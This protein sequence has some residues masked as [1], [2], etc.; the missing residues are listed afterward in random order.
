MYV[1]DMIY[2]RKSYVPNSDP[3]WTPNVMFDIEE[4]EFLTDILFPIT[5]VRIK[6]AVNDTTDAIMLE[7]THL[8]VM[9]NCAE[10]FW[11]I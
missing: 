3:W 7:L 4:L 2:K 1:I 11:E 9:I 8:Y 6:P 10:C 5:Q